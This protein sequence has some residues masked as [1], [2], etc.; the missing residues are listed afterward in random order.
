M[1]V[2]SMTIQPKVN[3]KGYKI[4]KK[5]YSQHQENEPPQQPEELATEL[6]QAIHSIMEEPPQGEEEGQLSPVSD[7]EEPTCVVD[8]QAAI[9][10]AVQAL[11]RITSNIRD[12]QRELDILHTQVETVLDNLRAHLPT[13]TFNNSPAHRQV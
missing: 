1:T 5:E 11:R 6:N 12:Q 10:E 9:L 8:S 7:Q 4:P 3:W 2:T 13:L